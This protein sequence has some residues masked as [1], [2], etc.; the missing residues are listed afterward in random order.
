[1]NPLDKLQQIKKVLFNEQ[2]APAPA[3]VPAPQQFGEYT[4]ADGT[5]VTIDKLE[6]GGVVM[7]GDAPAPVGEHLLADGTKIEVGEGG[8]ISEVEAP[9]APEEVAP[10]VPAEDMG[11]KFASLETSFAAMRGEFDAIKS[12]NANLKAA[13]ASQQE[14][15]QDLIGIVER[16]IGEPTTAPTVTPNNFKAVGLT[17]KQE[18]ALEFS[19]ILNKYKQK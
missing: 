15:M 6:V 9:E 17:S 2:P 5:V 12:E 13:L 7:L 14:A 11:A 10:V 3:P 1:M 8:V 19:T 16:I 18:K 4:L